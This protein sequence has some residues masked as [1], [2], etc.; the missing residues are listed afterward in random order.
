M[1]YSLA[2]D[3]VSLL[4]LR[5]RYAR[6]IEVAQNKD[7]LKLAVAG[8]GAGDASPAAYSRAMAESDLFSGWLNSAKKRLLD[9]TAVKTAQT[10]PAAAKP[11]P[12]GKKAG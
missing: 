4:R 5:S 11:A 6:L 9:K 7:T 12:S 3:D 2:N 8:I 10:A 1:A